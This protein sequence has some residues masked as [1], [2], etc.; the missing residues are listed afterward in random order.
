VAWEGGEGDVKIIVSPATPREIYNNLS[1]PARLSS[2][3]INNPNTKYKFLLFLIKYLLFLKKYLF[4]FLKKKK[5]R[6]NY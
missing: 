2:N 1:S 6:S 5:S 4:F 3:N